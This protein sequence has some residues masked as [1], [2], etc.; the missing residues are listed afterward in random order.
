M[1]PKGA[2][3]LLPSTFGKSEVHLT[4]FNCQKVP[5]GDEHRNGDPR[6]L[7]EREILHIVW[8][9]PGGGVRHNT[10]GA[11]EAPRNDVGPFSTWT[12]LNKGYSLSLHIVWF[13]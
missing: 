13:A 8:S 1:Q 2:A 11:N 12:K 3:D 5:K 7:V 9:S 4:H 10:Q 6:S